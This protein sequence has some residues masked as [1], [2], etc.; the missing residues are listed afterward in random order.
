M[1]WIAATGSYLPVRIVR[2]DEFDQFPPNSLRLIES[3]TGI[4]ERRFA[5]DDQ[6]NSDLAHEAAKACL[7]QAGIEPSD[8]DGVI[9]ATSS[10]DRMQPATATR[11]Q[12]LIGARRAWAF[13]VN[14]VCSGA[15]FALATANAM[16]QSLMARNILVVASEVYSRITNPRDFSTYPYFG[17]GAGAALVT[18]TSSRWRVGASVLAS[19]GSGSEKIQVPNGGKFTMVGKDVYEFAISKGPQILA[20]LVRAERISADT[21]AGVICHQANVNILREI[22]SRSGISFERFFVNLDRYGNT[23][24]ASVLIA[25]DEF[26]AEA[27]P[28]SGS[29]VLL[30]AFGG[31]LSWGG[32]SISVED[33]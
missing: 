29:R 15:V 11:V 3:K 7:D 26:L 1:A 9:V 13:D 27:R 32:I 16:V 18:S 4:R 20:E 24:A 12:H 25:L 31:G 21:I 6:L 19:D 28:T 8:I 22:A 33:E 10:P 17:D 5:A 2:N 23:A 30:A 14:S